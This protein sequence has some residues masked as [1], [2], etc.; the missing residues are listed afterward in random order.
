MTKSSKK[1]LNGIRFGFIAGDDP[2]EIGHNHGKIFKKEIND[3]VEGAENY[4]Q[5]KVGKIPRKLLFNFLFFRTK[6][7]QSKFTDEQLEE[8]NGIADGSGVSANYAL[9]AGVIYEFA[10]AL[11]KHL[12]LTETPVGCSA[13]LGRMKKDDSVIF[14]KTTD[15][16]FPD[17]FTQ[18]MTDARTAF[19]YNLKWKKRKFITLSYP[20]AFCGDSIF[21]ES[22]IGVGFNDGG[23]FEKKVNNDYFTILRIMREVAEDCDTTTQVLQ[24]IEQLPSMKPYTLLTTDGDKQSSY[25]LDFSMGEYEKQELITHLVN[26][27]HFKSSRMMKHYYRDGYEQEDD[28][29]YKN[30]EVRYKEIHKRMKE[31]DSLEDA[32]AILKYHTEDFDWNKGSI[33]NS[34]TVQGFLFDPK[35]RILML[36]AGNKIPVTSFGKWEKF[37]IDELFRWI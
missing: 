33:S 18:I 13:F 19:V 12:H 15:F 35:N 7:F 25:L 28:P 20:I 17:I 30:T 5:Q 1:I 21:T 8:M 9:A 34:T 26:T 4:V 32:I 24:K 16:G 3:L 22:G 29:F 31:F 11:E 14:A 37:K 2:Y 10:F 36:P 23:F 6:R 27:N